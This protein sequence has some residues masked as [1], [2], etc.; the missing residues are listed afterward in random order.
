M[1]ETSGS[2]VFRSGV[3]TQFIEVHRPAEGPFSDQIP[4]LSCRDIL[5]VRSTPI[6]VRHALLVDLEP[7]YPIPRLGKLGGERK[8]R[9]AKPNHP[10]S[11]GAALH[12]TRE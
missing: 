8:A 9:I 5:D 2:F 1:C 6:Q 7:G 10:Y 3:G 11:S 4:H 12:A